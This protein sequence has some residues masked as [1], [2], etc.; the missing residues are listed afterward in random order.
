MGGFTLKSCKTQRDLANYDTNNEKH[1]ETSFEID[2]NPTRHS[3]LKPAV[4]DRHHFKREIPNV[5]VNEIDVLS[6]T[7]TMRSSIDL[8]NE[9][10]K[11]DK[12]FSFFKNTLYKNKLS[13]RLEKVRNSENTYENN[14][15][16]SKNIYYKRQSAQEGQIAN[17]LFLKDSPKVDKEPQMSKDLKQDSA[18]NIE[19]EQNEDNAINSLE[20]NK[21][22]TNTLKFKLESDERPIKPATIM[23][24][25]EIDSKNLSCSFGARIT[26][27]GQTKPTTQTHNYEVNA[28][29]VSI[30]IMQDST[31][32]ILGQSL[33]SR[34]DHQV[35]VSTPMFSSKSPRKKNVKPRPEIN[36]KYPLSYH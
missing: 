33:T 7:G 29:K 16:K 30:N 31:P 22:V 34:E 32:S 26:P 8:L 9:A 35:M 5:Q 12:G 1:M 11:Q 13:D 2:A 10:Q 4:T 28:H 3:D 27:K 18:E 20:I 19:N 24:Q 15:L 6:L 25:P 14:D 23:F 36:S 21:L 17:K